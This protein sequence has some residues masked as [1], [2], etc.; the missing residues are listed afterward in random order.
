VIFP[1]DIARKIARGEKTMIRRVVDERST[2]EFGFCSIK[3]GRRYAVEHT[4][5]RRVSE[6]DRET[7]ERVHVAWMVVTEVRKERLRDI[8]PADAAAEGFT[9]RGFGAVEEFLADWRERRGHDADIDQEVWAIRFEVEAEMPMYLAS[10][11]IGPPHGDY[12]TSPR[13]AADDA[14]VVDEA[15]ASKY[16]GQARLG[17]EQQAAINQARRER[18]ELEQRLSRAREE[19]ELRGVD[20]SSPLRVIERQ[21]AAIE[22]RVYE[23]KAA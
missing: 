6:V 3:V 15:T 16:A 5:R 9:R 7:R 23:G 13:R 8:A 20:I 17:A 14:E 4:A 10:G 2:D 19:A 21:L 12:T 18:H 11:V 22:R 1:P